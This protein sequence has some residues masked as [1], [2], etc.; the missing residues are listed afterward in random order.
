M[1]VVAIGVALRPSQHVPRL[2]SA[3]IRKDQPLLATEECKFRA[4][5]TSPIVPRMTARLFGVL[6][7]ALRGVDLDVSLLEDETSIIVL[8]TGPGCLIVEEI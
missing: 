7:Y 8:G 3:Y 1:Y 2:Q 4:V 5:D 6:R